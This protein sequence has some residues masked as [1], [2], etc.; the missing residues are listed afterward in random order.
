MYNVGDDVKRLFLK[1]Y[2]QVCEL[3]S[4]DGQIKL[5]ETD[6]REG[7]LTVDR[8]TSNGSRID[9]GSVAAAQL[10]LTLDNR[11]GRFDGVNFEGVELFLR[12]G[13]KKWDAHAWEKA[14]VHWLPIGYFTVDEPP[15]KQRSISL[16]ALDRMV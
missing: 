7:G 8:Y 1:D 5:T 9:I 14:V 11:D 16:S 2:R 4:A 15:R 3:T 12:V 13:V 6:V 10:D